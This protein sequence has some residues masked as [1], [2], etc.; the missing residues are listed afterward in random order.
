[1]DYLGFLSVPSTDPAVMMQQSVRYLL[2]KE[3]S[4]HVQRLKAQ[5]YRAMLDLA[6]YAILGIPNWCKT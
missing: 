5:S 4:W 1:M 6:H 3:L 2:H